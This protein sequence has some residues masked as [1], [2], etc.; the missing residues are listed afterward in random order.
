[1]ISNILIPI[2]PYCG[3]VN[4]IAHSKYVDRCEECGKRYHKYTCYKSQQKKNPNWK[5]AHKLEEIRLE[6]LE[7]KRR[8]Y[9]VP[10]DIC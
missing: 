6:Y 5:R 2:C 4:C 9:K 10:K 8:G 3:K 1:M 7:L